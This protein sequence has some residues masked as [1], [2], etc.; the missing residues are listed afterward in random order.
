MGVPVVTLAGDKHISRVG[1]SLMSNLGHPEWIADDYGEYVA[2]A[3]ELAS[4]YRSL[5]TVRMGLR[6]EMAKS[7]LMD[8]EAFVTEFEQRLMAIWRNRND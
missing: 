2:I 4:D 5:N 3:T 8:N 1:I 7:P 6:E